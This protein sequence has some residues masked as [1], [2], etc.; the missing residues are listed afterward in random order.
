[1]NQG[2]WLEGLAGRQ[3]GRQYPCQATELFVEYRQQF[4]RRLP[5]FAWSFFLS[6]RHERFAIR[7][8]P[9]AGRDGFDGTVKM[10]NSILELPTR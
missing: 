10:I 3:P 5:L 8:E 6:L 2:R 9:S 7:R 1:V 4:R